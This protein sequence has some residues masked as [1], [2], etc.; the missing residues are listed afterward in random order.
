MH[1]VMRVR[2]ERVV[3]VAGIGL[4]TM[5]IWTGAPVFA[6]WVGSR[7]V[8]GSGNLTMTAAAG[9]VV[10]LAVTC[11]VL[12]R[13]LTRLSARYD[14]VTGRPPAPRQQPPWLRSMR[15]E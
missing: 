4:V 13:V 15:G 11:F 14:E 5:N 10:T 8:R 2:L 1:N 9:V 12:L 6:V 7:M 3:L